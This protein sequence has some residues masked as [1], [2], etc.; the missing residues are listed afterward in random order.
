MTTQDETAD[1]LRTKAE[2]AQGRRDQAA[3][4]RTLALTGRASVVSTAVLV[5]QLA[6]LQPADIIMNPQHFLEQF[7]ATAALALTNINSA[8]TLAERLANAH[9]MM[10]AEM[11][12]ITGLVLDLGAAKGVIP[13][14]H[15]AAEPAPAGPVL[16]VDNGKGKGA[17]R[18]RAQHPEKLN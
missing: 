17:R 14:E 18:G 6:A 1:Y 5:N 9:E 7:R 15:P 4:Y 8:A 10:A 2:L 11:D 12:Q 16:A 3:E 13:A